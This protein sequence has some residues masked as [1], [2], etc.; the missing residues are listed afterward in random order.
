MSWCLIL[1]PLMLVVVKNSKAKLQEA[2]KKI[3]WYWSEGKFVSCAGDSFCRPSIAGQRGKYLVNCMVCCLLAGAGAIFAPL[4]GVLELREDSEDTAS[5]T[6]SPKLENGSIEDVLQGY[7]TPGSVF[8]F[9]LVNLCG[10][11][12][13]AL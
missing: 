12:P 9:C 7:E 6:A 5:Q 11:K 4:A 2:I 13:P 3:I 10:Q 8:T 1:L